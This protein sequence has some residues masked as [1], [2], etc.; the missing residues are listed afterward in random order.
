MNTV[1]TADIDYVFL[2]IACLYITFVHHLCSS[3][4]S[5]FCSILCLWGSSRVL[6]AV[7]ASILL[8]CDI[9]SCKHIMWLLIHV[10]V[11]SSAA[12]D[13]LR[14]HSTFVV[15]EVYTY[16]CRHC[17]PVLPGGWRN[18]NDQQQYVWKR[19]ISTPT[20]LIGKACTEYCHGKLHVHKCLWVDPWWPVPQ[21]WL[22]LEIVTYK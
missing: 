6:C 1:W 4:F 20:F 19:Q 22:Y 15:G 5:F 16:L 11:A 17:S 18:L 3:G 10:C 8:W 12:T 13:L 7:V 21:R 2:N 14:T 9:S